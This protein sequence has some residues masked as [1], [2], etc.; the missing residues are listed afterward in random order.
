MRRACGCPVRAVGSFRAFESLRRDI[1]LF[2]VAQRPASSLIETIGRPISP[3]ALRENDQWRAARVAG[4]LETAKFFYFPAF[5]RCAPATPFRWS[6][7][8]FEIAI[9]R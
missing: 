4:A 6:G 7:R 9:D 3:G 8:S 2:S 5:A 1:R